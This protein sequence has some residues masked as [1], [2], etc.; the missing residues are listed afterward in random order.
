MQPPCLVGS[1]KSSQ[2]TSWGLRSA[3][4]SCKNST[5]LVVSGRGIMFKNIPLPGTFL[6]CLI[7]QI[8]SWLTLEGKGG[9]W[10]KGDCISQLRLLCQN[11]HRLGG[12]NNQSLFSHSS[13]GW[14]V[15]DQWLAASSSG[16]SSLLGLQMAAFLLCVHM[17]FLWS[18]CVAKGERASSFVSPLIR[19]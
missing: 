18:V 7:W 6:S 14:K 16:E 4:D 11:T 12:L 3:L 5:S 17:N 9:M 15:P 1:S 2:K 8:D 10:L 19:H 13:G